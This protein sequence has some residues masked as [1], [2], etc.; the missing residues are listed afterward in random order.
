MFFF[1]MWSFYLLIPAMI[2]AL[3][4]QAKVSTNLSR[5]SQVSTKKGMR[6]ADVA[7]AILADHGI[8]DVAIERLDQNAGDHY[9]PTH[10]K[11]RLSAH[12][13]DTS[14]VTAV[15]VAAHEAGHAIQHNESYSP[16][17][18]RGA[19]FPI[20]RF[21]SGAAI[22]LIF[23]GLFLG[24]GGDFAPILVDIGI[25]FFAVTVAFH[26]ITLPVEFNASRRAAEVLERG[27]FLTDDEMTGTKKVLSAAAMTYV[28]AATMAVMQLLRFLLLRGRS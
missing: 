5:F 22:P 21:T 26:I 11:I 7:A 13:H 10:K 17:V 27:R 3:Y 9:D 12:V 25:I 15:A 18:L 24:I 1:D 28:A 20:V 4:A 2:L 19:V 8:R 6:G 16:L 23:I 14:S